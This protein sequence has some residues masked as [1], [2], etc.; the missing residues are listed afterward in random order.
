MSSRILIA[1]DTQTVLDYLE[2]VFDKQG[3]ET[4][5]ATGGAHAIEQALEHDPDLVLVDVM[6]PDVDGFDVCRALRGDPKTS[7]LPILLYSA[8]VG[9]EVRARARAAGA[10]EFLGKSLHH[11]ELVS[12][13]RDWLATRSLPGGV[14]D[15]A[16]VEVGLDVLAL[17]EVEWVWLLR[18]VTDEFETAA[19][20]HKLGQQEA[21][22]MQKDV[23]GHSFSAQPDSLVGE[24]LRAGR[25]R[26]GWELED[27]ASLQDGDR[28]ARAARRADARAITAAPL[29]VTDTGKGVLLASSSASLARD[30]AGGQRVGIALRYASLALAV[31]P[32]DLLTADRSGVSEE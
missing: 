5:R 24:V 12:R 21:H 1:D 23:E 14:G 18:E 8:V 26:A 17:L 3:F 10:D 29:G 28:I 27:V 16:M 6:M 20:V 4:I 22:H 32:K 7:H 19:V 31:G 2:L 15:P 11:A 9:E 25:L 13:V 30:R